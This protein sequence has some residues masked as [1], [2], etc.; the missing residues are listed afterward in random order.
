VDV[1][2]A[3]PRSFSP[4][5]QFNLYIFFNL[6]YNY[7]LTFQLSLDFDSL[8]TKFFSFNLI[9]IFLIIF[10]LNFRFH[11]TRSNKNHVI[12]ERNNDKKMER[13]GPL[14][15]ENHVY[16]NNNHCLVNIVVVTINTCNQWNYS[17]L[18]IIITTTI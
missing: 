3:R 4:F 8:Y 17:S 6:I 7:I 2:G 18:V 1:W 13:K 14:K 16:Q 11:L 15:M 10:Q 5:L 9:L 12:R